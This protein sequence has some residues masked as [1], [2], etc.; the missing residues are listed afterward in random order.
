MIANAAVDIWRA[1]GADPTFKYED[2]ICQLR[3]PVLHGPFHDGDFSYDYD[4]EEV[5]SLISPLDIPWHPEKGTL[6]YSHKFIFLGLQWDASSKEVSLSS[7]K[8]LKFLERTR[9]FIRDFSSS[10]SSLRDVE[11]IH[12]S[13]CYVSF[14]YLEGRSHLSSLSNFAASFKGD[15]LLRRFPPRSLISDL[16][17]WH[18]TLSRDSFSRPLR[19]LGPHLDLSIFVDASTSWGIGLVINDLWMAFRLRDGWNTPLVNKDIPRGIGWLETVAVELV[20][21][22]IQGMGHSNCRILIHSDNMGVIG[23]MSKGRSPNYHI[24]L[25]IRR[26]FSVL[27]PAIIAPSLEYVESALN[28]ADPISRGILP[29]LGQLP[30]NFILPKVLSSVMSYASPHDVPST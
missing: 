28:L 10:Q 25:S 22:V 9:V 20:I 24:N 4:R 6:L 21:Y 12:G 14:V 17:W 27:F 13:L 23:A 5:L 18:H 8:R 11:K 1:E 2:D 16:K 7:H 30:L 26:T 3:Y 19:P 29:R 15:T